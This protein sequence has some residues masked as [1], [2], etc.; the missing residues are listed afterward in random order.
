MTV[1]AVRTVHEHEQ[2]RYVPYVALLFIGTYSIVPNF[3]FIAL[4]VFGWPDPKKWV[5]LLTWEVTTPEAVRSSAVI[6][7]LADMSYS[8]YTHLFHLLNSQGC[9]WCHL[10][11]C[12]RSCWQLTLL[13]RESPFLT[14]YSSLIPVV[15]KRTGI[16]M[17]F[18]CC[19]VNS[20]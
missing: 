8:V 7:V 15:L 16:W 19:S 6:V 12:A 10:V 1:S 17:C 4:I 3:I 20:V 11:A 9:F 18:L 5:S 2:L 14:L 13:K